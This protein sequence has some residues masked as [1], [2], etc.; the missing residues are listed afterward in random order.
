MY[1]QAPRLPVHPNNELIKLKLAMNKKPY[2]QPQ[3]HCVNIRF[4]NSL[5]ANSFKV[6]GNAGFNE[7]IAGGNDY[8]RSRSFDDDDW[9]DEE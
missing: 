7:D 3:L 1:G 4:E 9:F 2:Q 5:L 6:A 8:A